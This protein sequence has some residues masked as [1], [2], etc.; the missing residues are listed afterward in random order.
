MDGCGWRDRGRDCEQHR[1]TQG[2]TIAFSLLVGI[3]CSIVFYAKR[4]GYDIAELT[5]GCTT[6]AG[7]A[8]LAWSV[9]SNP[10]SMQ[11]G[12][13]YFFLYPLY[14]LIP[15]QAFRWIPGYTDFEIAKIVG[16]LGIMVLVYHSNP[17]WV[18][19]ILVL[20][21]VF[22]GILCYTFDFNWLVKHGNKNLAFGY[23]AFR[24]HIR[25]STIVFAGVIAGYQLFKTERGAWKFFGAASAIFGV[26][27][28]FAAYSNIVIIITVLAGLAILLHEGKTKIAFAAA[29]ICIVGILVF[30]GG[31]DFWIGND[32]GRCQMIWYALHGITDSV[33]SFF[34]GHGAGSWILNVG[35]FDAKQS[36]HPHNEAL[37]ILYE[38][39]TAGLI[40]LAS[41][42]VL[43][44]YFGSGSFLA[45]LG[46]IMVLFSSLG[47]SLRYPEIVFITAVFAGLCLAASKEAIHLPDY[48]VDSGPWHWASVL[49]LTVFAFAFYVSYEQVRSDIMLSRMRQ[50]SPFVRYIA[51]ET[52]RSWEARY[53]RNAAFFSS[54]AAMK[55][56]PRIHVA[57]AKTYN[58]V[59]E[60]YRRAPGYKELPTMMKSL[61]QLLEGGAQ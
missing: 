5:A 7:I 25:Y 61:N 36:G 31:K 44:I 27:G 3:L 40:V 21:A 28:I 4:T 33:T 51:L 2:A 8:V 19:R 23:G 58:D 59:S 53:Y 13:V 42:A 17:K 6:M 49:F 18:W 20:F 22:H 35:V 11:K 29:I 54:C 52:A 12:M 56:D 9:L 57:F 14:F 46:F 37:H 32:A 38:Y 39:G 48:D 43:V 41:Y 34:V 15:L 16:A 47:N 45:Q 26:V 24:N 1:L 10:A 50:Q 30:Y 55:D 60:M